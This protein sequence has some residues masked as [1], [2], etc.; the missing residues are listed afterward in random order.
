[1][2]TYSIKISL[3][4][5]L[6]SFVVV[7]F[8][9]EAAAGAAVAASS[10]WLDWTMQ[11]IVIVMGVATAIAAVGAIFHLNNQLMELN[12]V[13]VLQEHGIEVAE[14]IQ[15]IARESLLQRWYKKMTQAVP[16]EKES[17]VMLDH[18]YDGIRELDNILPPWW[19]GLFYATIFIGIGYFSYYHISD[20]GLSSSEKY[21]VEMEEAAEAVKAYLATQADQVDETNVEA[22][23]DADQLALGE[24]IF[25]TQCAVCHMADGGGGVGPNLTDEYWLHGGD[26]KDIFTTIKYGVPEK[27]MISWKAQL[28]AG[29]MQRV[30]SYILTLGGTTPANP[31]APEGDLYTPAA[32][33]VPAE[34]ADATANGQLGM[35]QE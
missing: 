27:G 13:R 3:T 10:G 5:L 28:R 11:N 8:G 32:D 29:D 34:E 30:A 18:N 24:S 9:Q 19:V 16:I 6:L 26:I 25:N 1:M 21:A 12:R 17:D 20:K 15:L 35:N 14:K 7:A 2:K 23:V 4:L 31:K 33:E 22:L